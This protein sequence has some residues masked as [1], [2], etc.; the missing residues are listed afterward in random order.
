MFRIK[1]RTKHFLFNNKLGKFKEKPEFGDLLTS[2]R[3]FPIVLRSGTFS[4]SMLLL[5]L[6]PITNHYEYFIG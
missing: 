5:G 6:H 4:T 3:H 2:Q 1:F